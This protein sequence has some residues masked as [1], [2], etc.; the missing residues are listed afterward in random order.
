M[1][2]PMPEA[3]EAYLSPQAREEALDARASHLGAQVIEIGRTVQ[4]RPI[5]AAYL[6]HADASA[7]HV[8]V[9]ANIH[10]VEFIATQVALGF[11]NAMASPVPQMQS[12]MARASIWVLPS[13]NPDAYARTW[14]QRGEGTLKELRCNANGVDLNR[15]YPPPGPQPRWAVSMGGWATGSTDQ[16]N[17]FYRGT[18]PLSEPETAALAKLMGAHHFV[19]S[20]NFH[21]T[22]GTLFPAHVK[23]AASFKAYKTLTRALRDA[24]PTH[25]YLPLSSRRLD[26]FTGEQ[27]DYQHHEHGCWSVCVETFTLRAS[28]R[29]HRNAPSL[30]WRFNPYDPEPWVNNDVP[31]AVAFFLAALDTP[32]P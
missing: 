5:R 10:G 13:L 25:H 14:A 31:G 8:L 6:P 2:Q 11:L 16:S 24:Q 26:W 7:P 17:A 27:E 21:S 4:D 30:F 28:R 12:L 9:C 22:M 19:A 32:M 20:A 18:G 29:Q 1:T 3:F 15:N 23:D